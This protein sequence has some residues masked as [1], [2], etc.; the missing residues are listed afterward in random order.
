MP[1]SSS[2]LWGKVDELIHIGRRMRSIA[3]QNA[4]GGMAFSILG[5]LAA[6]SGGRL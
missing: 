3:L 6:A 4:V 1:S 2:H 5:M